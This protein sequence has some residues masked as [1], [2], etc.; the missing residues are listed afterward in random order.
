MSTSSCCR[1]HYAEFVPSRPCSG[2]IHQADLAALRR[3][4]RRERRYGLTTRAETRL[5]QLYSL[6]RGERLFS[7]VLF[8]ENQTGTTLTKNGSVTCDNTNQ[9]KV[10]A[11]SGS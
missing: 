4:R 9:G 6:N 10:L 2:R 3:V 5:P 1:A 7:T 8:S 11:A